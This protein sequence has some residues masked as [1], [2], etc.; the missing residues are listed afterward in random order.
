MAASKYR[1]VLTAQQILHIITLAK[2]ESPL[3][4]LSIEVIGKLAPFQAKIENA[5]IVPAY[6]LAEP[7]ASLLESIG[8]E[9]AST[10]KPK[11]VYWEECYDKF[12]KHGAAK[13]SLDE[14]AAAQEHRY[15]NELMSPE[16]LAVF[17]ERFL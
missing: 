2:E 1:P 16:E 15:I 3:S 14:I 11:E 12:F 10:N 17:E 5:G 9:I 6:T 7:R 8:G 13:C 4:S